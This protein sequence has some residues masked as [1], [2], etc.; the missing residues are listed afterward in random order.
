MTVFAI[1]LEIDASN[2]WDFSRTSLWNFLFS[3]CILHCMLSCICSICFTSL[4]NIRM[5]NII[6]GSLPN[7]VFLA[8]DLSIAGAALYERVWLDDF[9]RRAGSHGNTL[10][11]K[12]PSKVKAPQCRGVS[13]WRWCCL[14]TS[15]SRLKKLSL[16]KAL[17][18]LCLCSTW[19]SPLYSPSSHMEIRC[20]RFWL[21]GSLPLVFVG[22]TESELPLFPE[23]SAHSRFGCLNLWTWQQSS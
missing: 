15:T 21:W 22:S 11:D 19:N 12:L 8:L 23:G 17:S 2:L 4:A 5:I 3:L 1:K 16:A 6:L 14:W 10:L 9:S 7:G 20:R 18:A 13:W